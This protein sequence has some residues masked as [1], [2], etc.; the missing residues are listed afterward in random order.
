M[1]YLGAIVLMSMICS[2]C[3]AA[4]SGL[5]SFV[6][7]DCLGV[8]IH[9]MGTETRQVNQIASG[10]FR[11]IRMDFSWV[12]I[13][14]KKG[15]YDFKP[16]DELVDSLAA[17]GIRP[18]FILDYA[19]PLYDN[20]MAPHTDEGRAAFVAFAKAGVIHFKGRGVLW[21]LWNEP[22]GGFWRPQANVEDYVK[23][24]K[25]VYPAIKQ[26]DPDC[27]LLAPA[28]AGWD[29]GYIENA[30]KLGLLNY[31][32]AVSL[33][34]YGAP[35]PDD[36]AIYYSKIRSLIRKYA[37]TGREYPIISGE[38]G[39]SC[40]SKGISAERQG[41]Y[42]IRSF[43]TNIMS[44]CRLS[45]WYDWHDDGPNPDE[46]EHHFGTVDL[47]YNEKPAY[48]AM[49]TL[50]TELNGYAFS[51]RLWVDADDDYLALFGKDGDYRM[52]VWTTG[53]PHTVS[54]PLD[55]ASADI[56]SLTGERKHV[57]VKNGKLNVNL[58]GAVQYIEPA[59]KSRRWA[60]ESAWDVTAE[61]A[62]ESDGTV[63][64]VSS[65]ISGIDAKGEISVSADGLKSSKAKVVILPLKAEKTETSSSYVWDGK[66]DA[67]VQVTLS[68]EGMD[69]PLV[70]IVE[71]D[72]SACPRI[73]VLP[74]AGRDLLIAVHRASGPSSPRLKGELILGNV[75]GLRLD[76]DSAPF[77]L[78]PGQDNITLHLKTTQLP[79]SIFS[80]TCRLV[81]D[82]GNNIVRIP[83]R[84]YALVET[85]ADGR[86][87]DNIQKYRID[88]D[89]DPKV[90]GDAK[91][92]Y[93]TAPSGAPAGVCAKLDYSFGAGWRFVRVSQAARI[94]IADKPRW[95]KVWVKGDGGTGSAR[96]RLD[97]SGNQTFQPDLGVLNFTDWR[98]LEADMTGANC[99]HWGGKNDGKMSYPIS[100]NTLFLL[101]NTGGREQ[102]GT[103]YLGPVMLCYD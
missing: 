14:K 55:V 69:Q 1:K 32:D 23:L 50:S 27:L 59:E 28:L 99:G 44:G 95:V 15:E 75:N 40:F 49:R 56:V 3:A 53:E 26:A 35:K 11:F 82:K 72:T 54:V 79:A 83:T 7:P 9:F 51:K 42:I 91:L 8:N 22:N 70:R 66:P 10:G 85:F 98:C 100:W 2:I 31:T 57:D 96:L 64:K 48:I 41:E 97:D 101:D 34:A 87:G 60:L 61:T 18:L 62:Q 12:H 37:P 102:K 29:Y 30:F 33:H 81:D 84:R 5:P 24:A 39:Y 52:A 88:L 58:S 80:F 86:S 43:L 17:R 93:V 20:D 92:T 71:L 103:I 36:A 65:K 89:G 6:I 16:Y 13:E 25:L 90:P 45:I 38:W 4:P 63:A 19:N 74:P 21:E 94:P 68:V 76:K 47:N 46:N 77:E 73:D 67:R 78:G